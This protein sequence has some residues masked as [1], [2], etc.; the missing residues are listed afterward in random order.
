MKKK[1]YTKNTIFLNTFKQCWRCL[2][3]RIVWCLS[4]CTLVFLN[5]FRM[6]RNWC[7]F[8]KSTIVFRIEYST[9][10]RVNRSYTGRHYNILMLYG[11]RVEI[12]W[13]I[14]YLGVRQ[15]KCNIGFKDVHKKNNFHLKFFSHKMKMH[16]KGKKFRGV[17]KITSFMFH[18]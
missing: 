9:T 5:T 1:K 2:L 17:F 6:T 10:Y 4:V 7:M 13:S 11:L 18:W 8:F 14:I 3:L 12:I 16:V 15:L